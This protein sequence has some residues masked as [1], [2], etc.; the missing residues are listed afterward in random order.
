M[1]EACPHVEFV[2]VPLV[3]A[4]DP[5][6]SRPPP[7]A[8]LSG[9]VKLKDLIPRIE[10]VIETT[11]NLAGFVRLSVRNEVSRRQALIGRELA[12]LD[13]ADWRSL[14]AREATL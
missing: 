14:I 6:P 12:Y 8:R 5:D 9:P 3:A 11:E 1:S 7:P 10:S 4:L 13:R 2:T